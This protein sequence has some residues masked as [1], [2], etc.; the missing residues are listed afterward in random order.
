METSVAKSTLELE[1]QTSITHIGAASWL[2]PGRLDELE[3]LDQGVGS[4]A[5]VR[6]NL[7]EMWRINR[8][9]GGV[10]ALTSTLFPL[11]KYRAEPLSLVDLG[12]GSAEIPLLIARYAQKHFQPIKIYALDLSNRNLAI[13]QQTMAQEAQALQLADS[14]NAK[15]SAGVHLI[16][17]DVKSLPFAANEVDY[18][19]S[20][21]FLHHFA[22]DQVIALL[23]E[24]YQKA[25][26]GIVMTDLV[27]GYLPLLA[28]KLIQPLFARHYLTRHDGELSIRRA[29]SPDELATLAKAAG[30]KN[31]RVYR[32][33]PWRMTLVAEKPLV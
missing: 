20:T 24:V 7:R 19:I 2:M 17:A 4:T 6:T 16:Q 9:L 12:T 28:F 10:Q 25:R 21:L 32:H 29:Y 5:D 1:L 30:I 3:L 26:R 14:E 11:L 33:F 18:Y 8:W 23:R 31:V 15:T 13:A 22:P 27:R